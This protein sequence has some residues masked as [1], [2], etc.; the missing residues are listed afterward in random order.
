LNLASYEEVY[1]EFWFYA[2]L[3]SHDLFAYDLGAVTVR[4]PNPENSTIL[5]LLYVGYTGDLTADPTTDNGWRRALFRVPPKSRVDGVTVEFVLATDETG[6]GEGIYID[7]VRIVGTPDVDT[8]PIGNDTYGARQYEMKNTGQ[9]AGL[10]NDDSDLH[11]PEA[12]DLVSVS[13]DIVV[14]VIDTGVDVT[15]PHPDLNLGL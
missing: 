10:G 6:T 13:P 14:A 7:Q 5:G 9:I 8:D 2:K 15:H 1:I 12:W 4:A 11:V 3:G